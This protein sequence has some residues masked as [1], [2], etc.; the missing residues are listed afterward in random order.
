M[1]VVDA[2]VLQGLG[3]KIQAAD[4]EAAAR[5]NVTWTAMAP[6]RGLARALGMPSRP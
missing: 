4:R 6:L 5:R 1:S 2:M 3:G